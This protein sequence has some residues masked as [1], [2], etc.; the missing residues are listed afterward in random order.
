MDKCFP[1]G[2]NTALLLQLCAH[3]SALLIHLG[4]FLR[5]DN[6]HIDQVMLLRNRANL[7]GGIGG[8]KRREEKC[9]YGKLTV[10]LLFFSCLT[11]F[12]LD[13]SD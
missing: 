5:W 11:Y 4:V 1:K 12:Y 6:D 9:M 7:K 13:F 8:G 10:L 2:Q 3:N